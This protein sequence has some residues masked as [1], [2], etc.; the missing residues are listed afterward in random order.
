MD[1]FGI[2]KLL[3]SFLNYYQTN[4]NDKN[5]ADT[6]DKKPFVSLVDNLFQTVTD[7]QKQ[8]SPQEKPKDAP[9]LNYLESPSA[10]PL[11]S[12]MLSTMQSHD[13]FIKRVMEK[14]KNT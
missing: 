9:D 2:F 14:N 5:Q 8:P 7:K 10:K 13:L 4:S 12:R 11:Q 3:N 1:N 6:T